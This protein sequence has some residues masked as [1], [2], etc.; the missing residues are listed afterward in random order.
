MQPAIKLQEELV[1]KVG[2][3]KQEYELV[4]PNETIQT[5][6]D[7]WVDGKLGEDLRTPY[8]ERNELV[9][10][11]RKDD[12]TT[13]YRGKAWRRIRR[14]FSAEYDEAFTMALHKDVRKGIVKDQTRPDGRKLD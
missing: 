6:V 2:V 13:D 14:Q 5:D 9:Q 4:L 12:S 3:T 1:K 11:L 7:K 10:Q 8:P